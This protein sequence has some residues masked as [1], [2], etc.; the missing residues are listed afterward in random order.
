MPIP[1]WCLDNPGTILGTRTQV[2]DISSWTYKTYRQQNGQS[3]VTGEASLTVINYAYSSTKAPNWIHQFEV[4]A[5]EA[6]WGAARNASVSADASASGDCKPDSQGSSFSR[7]RLFPAATWRQGEA[8]FQT[9]ATARGAIGKCETTWKMDITNSGHPTRTTRFARDH[10]RCDNATGGRWRTVGC[11]VPWYAPTLTYSRS[12]YPGLASH[13]DRA[14]KS[15]LPGATAEAPLIRTT[16]AAVINTNRTR[17]CGDAPSLTGLSCDEYPFAT[18]RQGLSN[19]GER[20]TFDGCS[21]TGL[22]TQ[23]G[24]KGVSVCMIPVRD[25]NAQGG[26]N[27]AF[28]T[29]QRVLD[30]DRFTVKIVG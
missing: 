13:V 27:S 25:Q 29:Q 23:T 14:Q 28:Y 6:S 21:F 18:T 11:V 19:G 2:C 5:T 4:A 10:I 12:D 9:T 3:T 30:G 1:Q 7:G 20:R 16:D 24:S 17:A 22:P 8:G 15:G 26:L